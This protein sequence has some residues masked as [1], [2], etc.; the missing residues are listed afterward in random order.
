M[1]VILQDLR[2]ALRTLWKSP[3]VSFVA[4]LALTAGIGANTAIFSVVNAV[5]LQP[6][7]YAQPERLV[8]IWSGRE[9]D[10]EERSSVSYADFEDWRRD[11][12][13]FER[14]A[15]WGY[16]TML[17]RSG[18]EPVPLAG[19][20]ASSD[21]L[22][23]LGAQ[24]ELGR[25]YTAEE[26]APGAQPVVVISHAVW[27]QYFGGRPE[28]VG[29]AIAIGGKSATVVGVM[30]EGFVFPATSRRTDYFA[31]IAGPLVNQGAQRGNQSVKCAA[32][33]RPGVTVE[34]ARSEMA[35]ISQQLASAYPNTNAGRYAWLKSMQEDLV[36]DTRPALLIMLGAVALVLLIACANV[37]NL[38]FA[39]ATARQRELSIRAALGASR[40]RLVRQLL[41]EALVLSIAGAAGGLL[42]AVWGLD[43]LVKLSS[44]NIPR[45]TGVALDGPVLA[46]TAGI[47][48]LTTLVA[49]IAPAIALSKP[50]LSDALK[51]GSRGSTEGAGSR[52][53]RSALVA[54]QFALS[55][56]LLV[57]AGLLMRSF[58]ALN[59][60]DPG[61]DPRGVVAVSLNP[62][63]ASYPDADARARYFRQTTEA[64][65]ASPG[66]ESAGLVAPLP[67]S[68]WE[69]SSSFSIEGQPPYEPGRE[70]I[71]DNRA[72]NGDYFR[73]MRIPVL[74]GRVFDERDSKDAPPVAII[75]ETFAKR[76]F[77][78]ESALGHR[79][80]IDQ[81]T[82]AGPVTIAREIVGVVG[83]AH[84]AAL[85]T[86]PGP[87]YY[88]AYTQD[89]E[90]SLSVVVRGTGATAGSVRDT[91]RSVD[92]GEY[93]DTPRDLES[94]VGSSINRQ[95]FNT[96][97]LGI[98]AAVALLLATVGIYGVMAY[99]VAQRTHEIGIRMAL[100]ASARQIL[101]QVI[102]QGL[103]MA[104]VGTGVGLVGAV[105]LCRAI[106]SL[107]F[108]V[109]STDAVTFAAVPLVLVAVA[110]AACYVP[111]RWA[112][113]VDPMIA[114]RDE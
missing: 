112:A 37:A 28:A 79:I 17:L 20:S 8:N 75:N 44:G 35:G 1:D 18:P 48:L 19:V 33:L 38:L 32:R 81:D 43:A 89:D 9:G 102:G 83:D 56:M 111:A 104:L 103:A 50:E 3:G 85:D 27:Q 14:M 15:A 80:L 49:G 45:M 65:A 16:K 59:N 34:E 99:A 53:T 25:L 69:M 71:A 107:L 29:S 23:M 77:P 100:G 73:A 94:Y 22:P 13:S 39:R 84:H 51:E 6:L 87:E 92:R 2:Y 95:R 101:R 78:G 74:A 76:Y 54:V 5:L 98:F 47:A 30:P 11:N 61:F 108:G 40:T 70:P 12:R 90:A 97:L 110:V 64:L 57:G 66:V 88:L 31:P 7:H 24:P 58:V 21:L 67:F 62:S 91:I 106:E 26:D 93:V 86:V 63:R 4:V 96:L 114:L 68:G 36:G 42:L 82:D 55:V 10:P 52:R 113:R 46:F 72:A 60:V 41:V 109:S 105:L